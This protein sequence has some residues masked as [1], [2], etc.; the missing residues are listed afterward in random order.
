MLVPSLK[1]KK[2]VQ[3]IF[4]DGGVSMANN[5]GLHSFLISQIPSYGFNWKKGADKLQIV[6]VGTGYDTKNETTDKIYKWWIKDWASKVPDI[7][8]SDAKIHNEMLLQ[9]LS[10]S[11]TKRKFDRVMLDLDGLLI[12]DQPSLF[13]LRY[14]VPLNK[15]TLSSLGIDNITT[16]SLKE[17]LQIDSDKT[18]QKL[19]EIG[20]LS[21][22][23]KMQAI[24]FKAI[25]DP[26]GAQLIADNR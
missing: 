11:P 25:F 9:A 15:E 12:A 17:L 10:D 14:D 16:K 18:A 6:S 4:T 5:P 22:E 24:H 20:L 19:Y 2:S 8:L 3:G 13:Y 1:L 26:E 7:L 21:A 23:Q